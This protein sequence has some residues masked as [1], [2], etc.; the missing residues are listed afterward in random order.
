MT[1]DSCIRC[2]T[3]L[4]CYCYVNGRCDGTGPRTPLTGEMLTNNNSYLVVTNEAG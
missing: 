3:V 2:V 1:I 4:L